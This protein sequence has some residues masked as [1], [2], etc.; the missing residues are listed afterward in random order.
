M[1]RTDQRER[2]VLLRRKTHA[3]VIHQ[4]GFGH[5]RE[6]SLVDLNCQRPFTIVLNLAE[7]NLAILALGGID[8]VSCVVVR[9]MK[10]RFLRRD[11]EVFESILLRQGITEGRPFVVSTER[12]DKPAMGRAAFSE[13]DNELVVVVADCLS[14]GVNGRIRAVVTCSR[15]L[16]D[17][18]AGFKRD[19]VLDC[20]S[21][22]RIGNNQPIIIRY[23]VSR[24]AL[25]LANVLEIERYGDI[26]IRGFE[27]KPRLSGTNGTDAG[28]G[29]KDAGNITARR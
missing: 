22:A 19:I 1:Q 12:Q 4:P 20:Q 24:A 27:Q 15:D 11:D 2:S 18:K 29:E 25:P 26:S 7:W 13:F 10:L 8:G 9:E 5:R 28:K 17:F 16:D 14:L 6:K 3:S 21:Q 23:G